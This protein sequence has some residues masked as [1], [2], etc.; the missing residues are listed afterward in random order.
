MTTNIDALTAFIAPST[1]T[2]TEPAVTKSADA[3]AALVALAH[4]KMATAEKG[5]AASR[6]AQQSARV[7]LG[8][9][10]SELAKVCR[11]VVNASGVDAERRTAELVLQLMAVAEAALNAK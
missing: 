8:D 10:L 3:A 6:M 4:R 2:V 7:I 1:D 9:G 5:N 11:K